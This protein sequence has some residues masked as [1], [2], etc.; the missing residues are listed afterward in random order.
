MREHFFAR[1][2]HAPESSRNSERLLVLG[3]LRLVKKPCVA[4]QKART[5]ATFN[6]VI[7]S[8]YHHHFRHP[9]MHAQALGTGAS[10]RQ[11]SV[12]VINCSEM[13][14]VGPQQRCL[15]NYVV[16]ARSPKFLRILCQLLFPEPNVRPQL[17]LQN[18]AVIRNCG[19]VQSDKSSRARG[20]LRLPA[21]RRPRT[22]NMTPPLIHE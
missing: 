12:M 18:P 19:D 14:Q 4:M 11:N 8:L 9:V 21:S 2:R 17:H 22:S 15:H 16:I 5:L 1:L 13:L 7:S 6:H 10:P 3:E 20:G